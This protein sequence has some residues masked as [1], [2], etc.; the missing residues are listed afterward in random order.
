[1]LN[2]GVYCTRSCYVFSRPC[3]SSRPPP[4]YLFIFF[5]GGNQ[6]ENAVCQFPWRRAR[7]FMEAL[8]SVLSNDSCSLTFCQI[9]GL[10]GRVYLSQQHRPLHGYS[11]CSGTKGKEEKRK[12]KKSG[13]LCLCHFIPLNVYLWSF[14]TPEWTRL[15]PETSGARRRKGTPTLLLPF[16]VLEDERMHISFTLGYR[17]KII[18]RY[19]PRNQINNRLSG[20]I[21][22]GVMWFSFSW[23]RNSWNVYLRFDKTIANAILK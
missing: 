8:K 15:D 5:G 23:G 6:R 17:G 14:A 20:F 13:K 3:T 9:R 7:R 11:Q 18:S 19:T 21:K 4:L 12:K 16:N 1:M 22:L 2:C 10:F